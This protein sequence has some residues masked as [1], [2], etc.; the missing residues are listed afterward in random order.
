LFVSSAFC[1][2]LENKDFENHN[3]FTCLIKGI[4]L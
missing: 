2:F 3:N 4:V 1:L